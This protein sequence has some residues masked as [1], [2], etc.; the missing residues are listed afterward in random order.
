MND[1]AV[2]AAS[3]QIVVEDVFP[4]APGTIWRTLT[5]GALMARWIRMEPTGFAPVVGNRFTYQ[6]RPEGAWDGIIR[7]EVLEVIE[8]RRFSYSWTGGDE[9]NSGYGSRLD[10]VVTFTLEPVDTGTRLRVVHSGFALPRNEV[11]FRNMSGGWS[12]VSQRIGDIAAETL[13]Q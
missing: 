6:T 4:H 5:S 10:T 9:N 7:C 13:S 1:T 3:R 2:H 12:T 8:N 11:A